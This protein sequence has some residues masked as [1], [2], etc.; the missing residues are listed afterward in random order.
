MSPENRLVNKALLVF[1]SGDRR[2]ESG[3]DAKVSQDSG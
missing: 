3:E 1:D 2:I